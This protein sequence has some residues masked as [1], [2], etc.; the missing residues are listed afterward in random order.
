MIINGN[1]IRLKL[2]YP[3]RYIEEASQNRSVVWFVARRESYNDMMKSNDIA[4]DS[5]DAI[6]KELLYNKQNSLFQEASLKVYPNPFGDYITI[7]SPVDDE[8]LIQEPTGRIVIQQRISK[9]QNRIQT[10]RLTDGIYFVRFFNQSQTF[11][12]V[13]KW[14]Y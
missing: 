9:G 14:E 12:I 13:K 5:T 10:E 8:I 7:E 6:L 11:K 3:E 2:R 4:E 1:N